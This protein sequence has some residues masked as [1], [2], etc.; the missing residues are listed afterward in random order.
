MELLVVGGALVDIR[1]KCEG[2]TAL[3]L[4]AMSGNIGAVQSLIACGADTR[5]QSL[6]GETAL[7]VAMKGHHYSIAK[8]LLSMTRPATP[9]ALF[10]DIPYVEA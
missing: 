3:H 7:Q 6:A 4:A 10:R 2:E 8:M 1:T 9:Q 5:S